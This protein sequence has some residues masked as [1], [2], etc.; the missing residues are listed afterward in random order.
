MTKESMSY[1]PYSNCAILK[2]KE[3]KEDFSGC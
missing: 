3:K 1:F 2:K